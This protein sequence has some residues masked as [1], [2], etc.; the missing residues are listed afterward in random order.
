MAEQILPSAQFRAQLKKRGGATASRCYQCATCSSV[1]ELAPEQA[2]FPRKQMH[3]VQWGLADRLAGDP[4]V[5]LCHYCND[6]TARCPRDAKPGDVMQAARSLTV[7]TLAFPGFMGKL[8]GRAKVTWPLLL[9]IPFA[10]WVIV[11]YLLNGL[12]IPG[13]PLIYDVLVPHWL[14]YAVFFPVTG[15]VLLASLVGGIRFWKLLGKNQKRTGSFIGSSIGALTEIAFHNRFG[16]CGTS[17]SRRWG[18][19]FLMWGFVGAAIATTLAI[20]ALY[21]IGE[22]PLPLDHPFTFVGN[23]AALFL[24]IGGLWLFFI[25]LKGGDPA[26][27]STAFDSFFLYVVLLVVITGILTEIGRFYFP[28]APAC[29]I[30]IAHLT[31]ILT[32]FATFPY[33]KFAHLIYRTLAMVH[34]RMAGLKATK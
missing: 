23:I 26:G 30:Y 11:L 6:C 27:T 2:P 20:I 9:G 24:L 33:S 34:E 22:Y 15:L 31:T 8:V 3:F 25:R 13:E 29:W 5:W 21:I 17:G 4:A 14:I 1:C 28:P 18:H 10:F 32:M 16:K 19:F 7:E 12:T